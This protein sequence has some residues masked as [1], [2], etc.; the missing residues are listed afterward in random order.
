MKSNVKIAFAFALQL[1]FSIFSR[2][3]L[4]FY[5]NQ[6]CL[7]EE[8]KSDLYIFTN[9]GLHFLSGGSSRHNKA[10]V[11]KVF[12]LQSSKYFLISRTK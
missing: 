10:I 7:N 9:L 2:M 4:E 12:F 5:I 3:G 11:F 6:N 1:I 8:S